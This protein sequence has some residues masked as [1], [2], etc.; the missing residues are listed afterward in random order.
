MQE[1]HI[2]ETDTLLDKAKQVHDFL[3]EVEAMGWANFVSE[4][5]KEKGYKSINDFAK[6]KG[7]RPE[8]FY[9]TQKLAFLRSLD[10]FFENETI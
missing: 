2:D 3:K 9:N 10:V 1:I 4:I 8:R 5:V 7:F 6:S